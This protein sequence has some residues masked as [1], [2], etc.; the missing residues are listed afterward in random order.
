M[1]LLLSKGVI[2][3]YLILKELFDDIA[4]IQGQQFKPTC[5]RLILL[6]AAGTI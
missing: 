1:L 2:A 3:S 6:D 4:L 5:N